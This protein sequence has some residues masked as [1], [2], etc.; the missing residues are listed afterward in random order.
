M[1]N[2]KDIGILLQIIKRCT[3]INDKIENIDL[4][5]FSTN[6]DLQE[7][8]CFNMFQIGEMANGLSF[9]FLK[10]NTLILWKHIIGLRNRIVHGYD[11]INLS[12]IWNTVKENILELKMYCEE[13]FKKSVSSLK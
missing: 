8:I 13:I 1:L 3:R 10:T 9:D 12:I 2:K 6:N 7:I 11:T 5:S 4:Y